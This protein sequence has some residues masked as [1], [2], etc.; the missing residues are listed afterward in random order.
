MKCC[1]LGA[2]GLRNPGYS[3]DTSSSEGSSVVDMSSS[4][5]LERIG[6]LIS[7]SDKDDIGGN[8]MVSSTFLC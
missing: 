8:P 7:S 5:S 3:G 6:S 4:A 2:E 1:M